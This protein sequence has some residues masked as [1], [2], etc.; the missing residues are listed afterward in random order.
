MP[1]GLQGTPAMFMQL[2]NKVL[3]KHLYTGVLVYLDDILIYIETPEEHDAGHGSTQKTT[4][5]PTLC[6]AV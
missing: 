6:E 1:F 4:A 5:I 3:H 2:I